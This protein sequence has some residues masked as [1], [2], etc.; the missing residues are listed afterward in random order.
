MLICHYL[1]P[2]KPILSKYNMYAVPM[3][4]SMKN[5]R[6]PT[7]EEVAE[8]VLALREQERAQKRGTNGHMTPLIYR[9]RFRSVLTE[10]R[11][12]K[13]T[14]RRNSDLCGV[15][16]KTLKLPYVDCSRRRQK[17]TA[18]H[19]RSLQTVTRVERRQKPAAPHSMSLRTVTRV[20]A[21]VRRWPPRRKSWMLQGVQI[22]TTSMRTLRIA[23]TLRMT[24]MRLMI[25]TCLKH[26]Y[27]RGFRRRQL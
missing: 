9:R 26:V 18:A 24:M 6:E 7:D 11:A 22:V 20:A 8:E 21:E 1:A 2:L 19:S 15:C 23:K 16:S 13:T 12:Y 17:P 27:N 10:S 5:M 4:Q 3:L 25:H 14:T